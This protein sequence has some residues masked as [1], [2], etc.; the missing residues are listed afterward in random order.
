M[1]HTECLMASLR[2][3]DGHRPESPAFCGGSFNGATNRDYFGATGTLTDTWKDRQ[4][5]HLPVGFTV[6]TDGSVIL[7]VK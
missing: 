1:A 2:E 5:H 7:T 4:P 3:V 6:M